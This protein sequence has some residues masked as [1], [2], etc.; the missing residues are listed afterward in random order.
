MT[1][2]PGALDPA[3]IG[4]LTWDTPNIRPLQDQVLIRL[5]P[6]KESPGG[7]IIPASNQEDAV[8]EAVIVAVG[9]GMNHWSKKQKRDVFKPTMVRVGQRV[10]VKRDPGWILGETRML[11]EGAIEAVLEDQEAAK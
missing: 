5:D 3:R 7:I 9:P 4:T 10:L 11:R 1:E 8:V 6:P 2:R